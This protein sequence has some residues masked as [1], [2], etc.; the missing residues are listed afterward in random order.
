MQ[1]VE[2]ITDKRFL[3]R[4]RELKIIQTMVGLYCRGNRHEIGAP[5]CTDCAALLAYATRRLERCVFGD[6]KPTCANCVVHCYG[7][8]MRER[9]RVVMRWAG[10]RM[11]VRHPI[12]AIAHLIDERRPV[13]MLPAKK[14][15]RATSV[16]AGTAG[17][18]VTRPGQDGSAGSALGETRR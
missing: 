8:G 1:I 9:I 2:F 12:M 16:V 4:R 17:R 6:A 3:R 5:L 15:G 14:S 13:P 10:P 18:E 7:A 11:M